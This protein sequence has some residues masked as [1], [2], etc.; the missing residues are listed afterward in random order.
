MFFFTRCD[1]FCDLLQYTHTENVM[2][3]TVRSFR[4]IPEWRAELFQIMITVFLLHLMLSLSLKIIVE[5]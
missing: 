4:I 5:T 1:V 2:K 3:M